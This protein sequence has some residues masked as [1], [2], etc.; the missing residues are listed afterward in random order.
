MILSS[1]T[2]GPVYGKDGRLRAY[3]HADGKKESYAYDSRSRVIS[4]TDRDG[5]HTNF[6]YTPDGFM[7]VLKPEGARS[8]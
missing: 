6:A 4:F 2:E 7:M 1:T 8:H 5:N 3:L